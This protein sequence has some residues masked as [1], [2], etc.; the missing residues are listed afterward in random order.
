MRRKAVNPNDL[1]E[2]AT[3]RVAA[4][5]AAINAVVMLLYEYGRKAVEDGLLDGP[6]RGV[7]FP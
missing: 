1:L 5:N 7:P 3:E 2:A 6:F 4:R